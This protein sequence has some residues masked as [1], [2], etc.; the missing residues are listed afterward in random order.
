MNAR[1][2]TKA[3]RTD[4]RGPGGDGAMKPPRLRRGL[5]PSPRAVAEALELRLGTA[6]RRCSCPVHLSCARLSFRATLHA[7]LSLLTRVCWVGTKII[8]CGGLGAQF[9]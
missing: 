8:C 5:D 9:G 6:V 3:V 7:G 1:A 4:S 2:S